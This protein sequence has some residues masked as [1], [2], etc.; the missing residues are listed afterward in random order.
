MGS[1]AF[2]IT[3]LTIVYSAVY[4]GADHRKHLHPHP[5]ANEHRWLVKAPRWIHSVPDASGFTD[6]DP[7]P[8][9][10]SP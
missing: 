3:S 9:G 4:S 8:W 1:M 2:Q 10:L 7:A 6:L 5:L